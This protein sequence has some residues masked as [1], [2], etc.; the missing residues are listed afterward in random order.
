MVEVFDSSK[1]FVMLAIAV[2]AAMLSGFVVGI[3][4]QSVGAGLAVCGALS[5]WIS[6]AEFL[7]LWQYNQDSC[8]RQGHS[9]V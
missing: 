1:G 8:A 3:A 7:L 2:I 9:V 4:N 6:C 5:A